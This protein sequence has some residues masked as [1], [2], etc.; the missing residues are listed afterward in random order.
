MI[1]F[2]SIGSPEEG[3]TNLEHTVG[4]P[5]VH[6]RRRWIV[7]STTAWVI[8]GGLGFALSIAWSMFA[9]P[10][11]GNGFV[12]DLVNAFLEALD[13]TLAG[14]AVALGQWLVFRSVLRNTKGWL[15]TS[16]LGWTLAGVLASL[17]YELFLYASRL[18]SGDPAG[19]QT[20]AQIGSL[21]AIAAGATMVGAFQWLA[22]RRG[23]PRAGAWI[24]ASALAWSLGIGLTLLTSATVSMNEG[25]SAGSLVLPIAGGLVA[26][27]ITG[28]AFA[29]LISLDAST[30]AVDAPNARRWPTL[31]LAGTWVFLLIGA[32]WQIWS[33]RAPY[34]A[35]AQL[36]LPEGC[37][38]ACASTS[39]SGLNLRGANLSHADLSGA[40]L[41]RAQLSEAQLGGAN[42]RAADLRRARL[43]RAQMN[44]SD[45]SG[46]D[47]RG[48]DLRD[49]NLRE[50]VLLGAIVDDTTRLDER[51]R[52]AW[53]IVNQGADGRNLSGVNLSGAQLAQARL[54][55]ADLSGASLSSSNLR[56]ADLR[57]ANLHGAG[58]DFAELQGADLTGADLEGVELTFPKLDSTTRIDP[59][60]RLAWEIDSKGLPGADLAGVDLSR[61]NL[62]GGK[63]EGANLSGANLSSAV[64]FHTYLSK[65]NLSK[66]NL[67]GAE[68]FDALLIDADFSGADLS[69]TILISADLTGANLA[70]AKLT[71][72]RYSPKTIWPAG[73]QPPPNAVK[74]EE[75]CYKDDN[76]KNLCY[77]D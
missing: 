34:A 64:L 62:H 70:E 1:P 41:S 67:H 15:L 29:R 4:T 69:D 58:L 30:D 57:N 33:L 73:F 18:T 66:A 17:A 24:L 51:W 45:L 31:A 71:G 25:F 10:G 65:A 59:K 72:A 3:A 8:G 44:G 75:P 21:V 76:R 55:G 48:S 5:P 9:Y 7:V 14:F 2:Q 40:N 60:W 46:A 16:A 11:G 22:L 19:L 43:S 63:L 35:L 12:S 56:G 36:K 77:Y 50:A 47:L 26:A 68:L 6:V 32:L 38:P 74:M 61:A 20:Y 28:E 23:L 13:F 49:A 53:E 54:A 37:P 27:A 42:L 39:L 52:V